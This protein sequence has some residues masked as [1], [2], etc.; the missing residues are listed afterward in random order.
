MDIL[1]NITLVLGI[2]IWIRMFFDLPDPDPIVRGMDPDSVPVS[3]VN[4]TKSEAQTF[5]YRS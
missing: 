2:R 5:R 4:D 1:Q 3:N